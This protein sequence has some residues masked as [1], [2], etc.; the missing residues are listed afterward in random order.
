MRVGIALS[1]PGEKFMLAQMGK[2]SSE[3]DKS[4]LAQ[5]CSVWITRLPAQET[6]GL[7][8][9]CDPQGG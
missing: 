9:T 6:G 5:F 2:S 1:L 8:K 4:S 3:L 7:Y